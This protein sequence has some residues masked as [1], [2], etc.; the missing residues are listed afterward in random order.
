MKIYSLSRRTDLIF[1]KFSGKVINRE[2]F[3]LIQTPENPGYHWGNYI[4]FAAPPRAGDYSK[5]LQIFKEEF[6]YYKEF[7]HMVFTWESKKPDPGQHKEFIENG[8][9]LDEG[10]VLATKELQVPRKFNS[11]IKVKK[12]LEDKQWLEVLNLQVLCAHSSFAGPEFEK[13]KEKQ[14]LQYR[15]MSEKGMGFWFGAYFQDKLVGDLGIFF[16]KDLARYQNVFTHPK[17][18]RQGICQ[19]LIYNSAQI[20]LEEF[21]VDTLV[22]EADA[23]YHAAKIYQSL[24]FKAVEKNFSLTWSKS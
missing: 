15:I 5:W 20:A 2:N 6:S 24:G 9:E 18:R 14:M 4:I 17:F 10:I 16:E 13:F 22:M 23:D 7:R 21:G 3:I 19:T 11:Q 8:F 12:I 1:S